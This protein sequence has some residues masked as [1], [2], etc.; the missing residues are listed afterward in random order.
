M[1]AE[2]VRLVFLKSMMLPGPHLRGSNVPAR[3]HRP[4]NL[5][6][7][8]QAWAL[9]AAVALLA[10]G[11]ASPP[12]KEPEARK[13]KPAA[14]ADLLADKA[15]DERIE[16][17]ARF[18][19]GIVFEMRD[20]PEQ[21]L[22]EFYKAANADPSNESL[23]L[24]V[25]RRLLRARRTEQ[26]VELLTKVTARGEASA[27]AHALLGQAYAQLEKNDL[28]IAANRRAIERA[29][30]SL[31]GYQNLHLLYLRNRQFKEALAVLNEAARA[32]AADAPFWLDLAEMFTRY[33]QARPGESEELK[34]RIVELLDRAAA[35]QPETPGLRLKL[36]DG[37]RLHGATDKA[38][39]LYLKLLEQSP[40][41][42][43]VRE[44]LTEMYLR[45]GDRK[46]AA[47]QLRELLRDNPT[48]VQGY[49]LLGVIASEEKQ[50]DEAAENFEKT[51]LLNPDF[52]EAY[53]DLAGVK[54]NSQKP[55][56][57]IAILGRARERFGATFVTEF[58]TGMAYSTMKRYPEALKA[59]TSAE[60]LARATDT[61][62]LTHLFYFQ[63]GTV[64]ERNKDYDQAATCFQ[65]ALELE[66]DF[67]D[68]LNYLGYMWADLGIRLDEARALLERA[69]KLEPDNA[70]FLD[71][72]GWVLFKLKRPREA[73]Q[74]L[75]RSA[76]LLK[77]PDATILDHLGDVHFELKNF[78]QARE[79][80]KKA[81]EIE[82]S[83]AI[84]TKLE[85]LP[86]RR[87]ATP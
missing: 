17:Y 48:N 69:V 33:A 62:R 38:A 43:T 83:E 79:A 36:A 19:S 15:A 12:R 81:L 44:K 9:S 58:Y 46:A 6:H 84:R 42:P 7:G 13:A 34:P 27:A 57:A 32:K 80:W 18:A 37:Y 66:P 63:L 65:R 67:A 3:P 31:A 51:L 10:A 21:A 45:G 5:R 60:L 28:A 26:V 23:A 78:D 61:N 24:E 40:R 73:L 52:Q 55:E 14:D 16:A 22:E 64:H 87:N 59:L 86:D 8:W 39:A 41:M 74:H 47:Q 25:S 71:S 56:E 85:K 77:E 35:L 75:E 54:I 68:A 29:P 76:S 49:Y 1:F 2:A 72:L 30:G 82:S 70:A 20:Q 4:V 11:C 50:A 53:Y